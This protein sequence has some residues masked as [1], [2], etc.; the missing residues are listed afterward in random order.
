MQ[1]RV[2][3]HFL[4]PGVEHSEVAD[5]C[6]ETAWIRGKG[7]QGFRDGAEQHVVNQADSVE[8][9]GKVHAAG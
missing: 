5:M 3:Q 8:P 4:T 2:S 7:Q 6:A 1:M 9:A